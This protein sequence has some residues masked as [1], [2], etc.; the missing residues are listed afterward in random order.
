MEA[1]K[2]HDR[3][4]SNIEK[5]SKAGTPHDSHVKKGDAAWRSCQA[6]IGIPRDGRCELDKMQTVFQIAFPV[7][8]ILAW[9]QGC[10]KIAWVNWKFGRSLEEYV[11][12]PGNCLL[13]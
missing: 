8:H 3:F 4:H 11:A 5:D 6:P 7:V 12:V 10:E 2:S 9:F 13:Q 1:G